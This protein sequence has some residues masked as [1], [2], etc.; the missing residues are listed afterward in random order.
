MART[1]CPDC[2]C[3]V[4]DGRCTNCHESLYILDQYDDLG[5]KHP[6]PESPLMQEADRAN[7]DIARKANKP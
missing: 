2:G 6:G 3:A 5:M 7:Q 1:S 4:Y